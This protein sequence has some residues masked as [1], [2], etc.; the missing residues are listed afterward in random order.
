MDILEIFD[1]DVYVE[2]LQRCGPEVIA[3]PRL[4]SLKITL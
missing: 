3:T 2:D 4:L 1:D